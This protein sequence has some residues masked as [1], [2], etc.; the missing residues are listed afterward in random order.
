MRVTSMTT[1]YMPLP[2]PPLPLAPM[3][4]PTVLVPP[5]SG[6]KVAMVEGPMLVGL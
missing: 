4:F 1:Q 6:P 3:G 2:V 5:L